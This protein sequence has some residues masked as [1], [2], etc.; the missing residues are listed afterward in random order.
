MLSACSTG[1]HSVQDF[2]QGLPLITSAP[3]PSKQDVVPDK[4]NL[5]SRSKLAPI[6][7]DFFFLHRV[8]I[9]SRGYHRTYFV[10]QSSHKLVEI[11]LRSPPKSQVCTATTPTLNSFG[12]SLLCWIVALF[13]REATICE[14]LRA[15]ATS[16]ADEKS[17]V[18]EAGCLG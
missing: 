2:L 5:T 12:F 8:S 10:D 13:A 6:F 7:M 14:L 4:V 3:F 17:V 15:G 9:H 18:S 11:H 1:V 16:E